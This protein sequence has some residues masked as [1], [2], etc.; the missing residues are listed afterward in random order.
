MRY[1]IYKGAI[2]NFPYC[3]CKK[4]NTLKLKRLRK[5]GQNH[6]SNLAMLQEL[7]EAN[8]IWLPDGEARPLGALLQGTYALGE[9][10]GNKKRVFC[11]PFGCPP[12]FFLH[13]PRKSRNFVLWFEGGTSEGMSRDARSLSPEN[14]KLQTQVPQDKI[15]DL[16]DFYSLFW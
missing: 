5:S 4:C 7:F 3:K 8:A 1:I 2:L 9:L 6:R 11:C 14:L 13:N 10:T 16:D 12:L 15:A